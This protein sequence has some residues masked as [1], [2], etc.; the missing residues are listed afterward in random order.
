M[1]S[2]ACLFAHGF[3]GV[4]GGRKTAYLR[5]RL[6]LQV[7]APHMTTL[8]W[9]FEDQVAV[10][11][12]AIDRDPEL[13]LL[14]GSSMGGFATAV[15]ASRRPD[16]DLRVVLMAPAVGIHQVWADQ[17]GEDGMKLWAEMG[18]IQYHHKGVGQDVMLPYRL[19]TQSLANAGVALEHPLVVVHGVDDDVIPIE[20]ALAF[21]KASPGLRRFSG[22]RDGHRLLESLDVMA[23]GIELALG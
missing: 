15:A 14:V 16:R 4:P 5:E 22:V 7:S 9:T 23:E 21:A 3:E 6:G 1:E 19:W 17:L 13:K 20:R 11:L 18:R 2:T 8:G 12:D 10:L